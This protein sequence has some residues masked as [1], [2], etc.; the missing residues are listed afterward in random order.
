MTPNEYADIIS[1]LRREVVPAIGCTEP[2]AVA[3]CVAKAREILG[4]EPE[5]LDVA[6]SPN[7]YKNAMGVGIP[8]TGMTGLPI[9]V[10]LGATIGRS[11]LALE[12]LRDT[13]PEAVE[14][15]KR[16][17]AEAAIRIDIDRATDKILYIR[18]EAAAGDDVAVAEIAD[19]HTHFT[20]LMLNGEP[21]ASGERDEVATSEAEADEGLGLTLRRVYE[22]ATTVPL[23]DVEFMWQAAE[24]NIAAAEMSFGGDYGHGLG[25][26]LHEKASGTIFGD[27]LFTQILSYTS[28][29]CDARM[30]GAMVPVMSNSGSGNQG[31]SATVP[32]VV[33]ARANNVERDQLLRAL[34][35][36][37]LT[38]IYIKESLG[39]LSA[40]CGGVV[41]ATGS[42]CGITY[43]MGGDY[44]QVTYA[45]KNMVANITG[46]ICDG[47][48][49]SCSL[50]V[51]SGVATAVL[52]AALAMEHRHTSSLEGIIDDDVDCCIRN[53]TSIGRSGMRETDRLI[54][55]IMTSK[56]R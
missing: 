5:R 4:R 39:R 40:L 25:R 46:M 55:E 1:V 49:P 42:S 43:L 29:A 32:V 18:V 8:N 31:I 6:L 19:S 26:L 12:V 11:E 33:F 21:L 13:T 2:V 14:A 3:L 56:K 15:A 38:V 28:G 27:T 7:I 45:V 36:S 51:T 30:S 17:M 47:A 52:S 48:K 54:L 35:L 9:A 10:A 22:F 24:L 37:H 44:E 50:K 23:A 20:A 41:A 16:Y 34:V 53:M